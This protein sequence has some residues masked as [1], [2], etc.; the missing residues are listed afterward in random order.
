MIACSIRSSRI[1]FG[2]QV[3]SVLTALP[4]LAFGKNSTTLIVFLMYFCV[5]G[6]V[7][8]PL[9]FAEEEAD[10]LKVREHLSIS[11]LTCTLFTITN[12]YVYYYLAAR[13]AG[14]WDGL[15]L[16]ALFCA[17]SVCFTAG[18]ILLAQCGTNR[19]KPLYHAAW[20][21]Y[22]IQVAVIAIV[23]VHSV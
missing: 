6:M 14:L 3:F 5:L 8:V 22:G 13:Q 17:P 1:A 16:P 11:L 9:A 12:F 7:T 20:V 19:L 23:I 2:L 21:F 4:L 18:M 15:L 10:F